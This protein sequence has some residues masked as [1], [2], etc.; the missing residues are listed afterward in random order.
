MDI[1]SELIMIIQGAFTGFMVAF[2]GYLKNV[3]EEGKL[4]EFNSAKFISTVLIGALA[5][6]VMAWYH[7]SYDIATNMLIQAGIVTIVEYFVKALFRWLYAKGYNVIPESPAEKVANLLASEDKV[8]KAYGEFLNRVF[9]FQEM[10][11]LDDRRKISDMLNDLA[12]K[13]ENFLMEAEQK[14]RGFSDSYLMDL[15]GRFLVKQRDIPMLLRAGDLSIVSD[16][17]GFFIKLQKVSAEGK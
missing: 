5:G 9:E 10:K 4:P 8:D 13:Y 7:V 3:D 17:L 12:S 16:L 15:S 2:L 6:V 1:T 14:N 11:L